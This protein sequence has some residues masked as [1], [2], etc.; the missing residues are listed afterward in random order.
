MGCY[1]TSLSNQTNQTQLGPYVLRHNVTLYP[2]SCL[3][4]LYQVSGD[5]NSSI[6]ICC[7]LLVCGEK[8]EVYLCLLIL[9][10][11][12][13]WTLK[14][15]GLC[16]VKE[17]LDS[18]NDL[19]FLSYAFSKYSWQSCGKRKGKLIFARKIKKKDWAQQGDGQLSRAESC[20]G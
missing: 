6:C 17:E 14:S 16:N 1:L 8:W 15:H 2:S 13:F 18:S 12:L 20:N 19:S 7:G 9:S 11:L 3:S 5:S 10:S 4:V